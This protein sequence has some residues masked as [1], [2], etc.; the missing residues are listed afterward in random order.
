MKT[1]LIVLLSVALLS[2]CKKEEDKEKITWSCNS[3]TGQF[4]MKC[5]I[6]TDSYCEFHIKYK[7]SGWSIEDSKSLKPGVNNFTFF[8]QLAC[9]DNIEILNMWY[10]F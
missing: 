1:L 7:A 6:I 2:G 10:E 4:I 8:H 9:P 5:E 3:A